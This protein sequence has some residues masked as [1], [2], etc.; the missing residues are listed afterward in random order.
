M[1]A[2]SWEGEPITW[3]SESDPPASSFKVGLSRSN[4]PNEPLWVGLLSRLGGLLQVEK[5]GGDGALVTLGLSSS[6]EEPQEDWDLTG[7]D[8]C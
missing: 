7:A 2:A 5:G 3:S 6:M 4:R 1:G 8:W